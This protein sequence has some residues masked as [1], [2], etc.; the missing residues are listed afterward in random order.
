MRACRRT[1]IRSARP[2]R[3]RSPSA[4]RWR[5]PACRSQAY[6]PTPT[7]PQTRTT[8]MYSTDRPPGGRWTAF[9]ASI[10]SHMPMASAYTSAPATRMRRMSGASLRVAAV[11]FI[12]LA[13]PGDALAGRP[14]GTGA[15][16]YFGDP[17][18]VYA[19]GRT[20]I[21]WA[22]TQ[23][24][25]HVAA[26][27]G[28]RLVEHQRLGP[29]L[30]VDDHNNPSLYVRED[31]RIMVFYSAHNGK[32]MYYRVS[33]RPRS[34]ARF[35]EPRTIGT[36][37][38]GRLGYTYPNPLRVDGRL[39]LV[40]RG[41]NW[42][43]SYTIRG[44]LVESPDAGP[45]AGLARGAAATPPRHGR[46]P[47][48]VHQVRQRRRAHP[49]GLHRGQSRGVPQLDLLRRVRPQRHL[50][51]AAGRRIARLGSAPPVR[52]LDRVRA[53]LRLQ[54]V[55]ARHRRQPVRPDHR[56]HA[57]APAARV[58][59][60]PVRRH[61]VAQLQDH[62]VRETPRSPGAVGG[63]TLDHENPNIV[64]LSRVVAGRTRHD[65][66]VWGTPDGGE[67][68]KHRTLTRARTDDLR[69]ITPRGLTDR[70]QVFWLSGTRMH[71]TSFSTR[72][73]AASPASPRQAA[74]GR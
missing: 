73:F 31:G 28:N 57:T 56:V 7:N 16:S 67:T 55:G 41:A 64:Y 52:K 15:W 74:S 71:W 24:Y 5:C 8:P 25:T 45:R 30:S 47:S 23:G 3:R 20:F 12:L 66:E 35:S 22:D 1:G 33:E 65:V 42:Q 69:P 36:N 34:I 11:L 29:P 13:L 68:W 58:L 48:A 43:P 50:H 39:W 61:E 53:V 14:I 59:V 72:I 10:S 18:A 26:L 62:R 63:A 54:A 2:G 70:N 49:R 32:T 9:G 46:A 19:G 6:E 21:G 60:G 27:D 51:D 40:F 37:T 4:C 44:V 17:R 38:A